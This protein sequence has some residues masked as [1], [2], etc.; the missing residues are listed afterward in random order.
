MCSLFWTDNIPGI[1]LLPQTD[2]GDIYPWTDLIRTNLVVGYISQCTLG[3]I[4]CY[5]SK[6][7]TSRALLVL[8]VLGVQ[9]TCHAVVLS[10]CE[11]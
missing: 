11:I 3:G 2:Q 10:D 7:N 8:S 1:V 5:Y 4:I 6:F 9:W